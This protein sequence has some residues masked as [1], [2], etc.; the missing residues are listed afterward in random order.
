LCS[1]YSD[2]ASA[3]GHTVKDQLSQPFVQALLAD[4][5]SNCDSGTQETCNWARGIIQ[6]TVQ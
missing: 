5:Y 2:I 6:A 1:L 3:M 4:A